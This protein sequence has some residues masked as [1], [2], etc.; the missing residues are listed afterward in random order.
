MT[1]DEHLLVLS[2]D[3]L[4]P[5]WS[6]TVI[7]LGHDAVQIKL[8]CHFEEVACW[9]LVCGHGLSTRHRLNE[10]IAFRAHGLRG[11]RCRQR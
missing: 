3:L 7:G 6:H 2:N 8:G 11:G 5:D 10:Q 4:G 1:F 9:H